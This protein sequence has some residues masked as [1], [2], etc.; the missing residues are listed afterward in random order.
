MISD[1][2]TWAWLCRGY[3]KRKTGSFVIAAQNNCIK[4]NYIKIMID[5]SQKNTR[6]HLCG[7]RDATANHIISEYSKLAP[8]KYKRVGTVKH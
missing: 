7:E 4:T 2:N 6:F 8:Q 3:L 1:V 5:K